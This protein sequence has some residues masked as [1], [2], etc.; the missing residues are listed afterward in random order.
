[1]NTDSK[2][3]LKKR[4]KD[5][6][7]GREVE[8]P[9]EVHRR[10]FGVGTLEDKIR[11]RHKSFKT[12]KELNQYLKTEAPYYISYSVAYYEF[13]SQ[14]MGDKRWLGADLI[15]D[16][17]KPM[18]LLNQTRLDEVKA[19]AVSLVGFLTDDFGFKGGEISVNFSG[20]KGYHIHVFSDEVKTLNQDA[21]REIID[22][23]TGTG[24]DMEY[25]V[26]NVDGPA[27]V[28]FE[29]GKAKAVAGSSVGPKPGSRG[30][31]KR[32]YAVT[33][34][35]INMPV[36]ELEKI[37]GVGKKTAEKLAARRAQNMR[38]LGDGKWDLL[39]GEFKSGIKKQIYSKAVAIKDEDRQVTM[40]TSRLI[41]LPGTI[42]GG[43]GLVAKKVKDV[44]TFNPLVH[45]LAFG[46]EKVGI[47][48][49]SDV[50]V[51]QLGG[52][53]YGPYTAGETA[54]L[55]E[56]AAVYLLLKDKAEIASTSAP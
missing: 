4:F 40:D 21:R 18:E 23:V 48:L 39:W 17:D 54:S 43:S 22:Y 50:G 29:R 45:A 51:F 12:G 7:W 3:F 49:S 26:R 27:G 19:E 44:S 36:E 32:I 11:F 8:A 33:E 1:M 10:E 25:F 28:R 35:L 47:I 42:H 15:F 41:R 2:V 13:P 31:A 9:G 46:K 5:Y 30:W 53:E 20:S 34:E 37:E 55:E 56:Y 6:Y 52:G 24:L 38:F 16:L 14:P